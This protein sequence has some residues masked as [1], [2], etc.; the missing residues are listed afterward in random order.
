MP[1]NSNCPSCGAPVHREFGEISY[2]E[3]CGSFLPVPEDESKLISDREKRESERKRLEIEAKH[4]EEM[5]RLDNQKISVTVIEKSG[6]IRRWSFCDICSLIFLLL[7]F[8]LFVFFLLAIE[9]IVS[10]RFVGAV[11]FLT[12]SFLLLTLVTH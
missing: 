11:F 2:C 5:K 6:R 9:E 7:L 3:Y 8:A 10:V 1:S 4:R 12:C